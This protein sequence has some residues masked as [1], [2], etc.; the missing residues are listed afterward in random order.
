MTEGTLTLLRLVGWLLPGLFGFFAG[1]LWQRRRVGLG[2][3]IAGA[4][5]A[6]LIKPLPLGWVLLLLGYL[7]GIWP[8][9]RL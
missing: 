2:L 7:T 5:I 9:R 3:L 4:L 6:I 8:P 1:R